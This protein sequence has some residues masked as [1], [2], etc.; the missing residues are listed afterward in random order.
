VAV[1]R[2]RKVRAVAL[3]EL[4]SVVRSKSWLIL[5]FGMPV[6]LLLYSGVVSIPILLEA[7]RERAVALHGVVDE[8][9]ILAL[10]GDVPVAA[11]IPDEIRDAL[12]IAGGEDALA[13][14]IAWSKNHVFRPFPGEAEARAAL[15]AGQIRSYF[16]LPPDFVG[17]GV[18][19]QYSGEAPE[20]AGSDS[21]SS[22][23]SLIVG[24]LL[25]G[26]VPADVAARVEKPIAE[27]RHWTVTDGGE[28][29]RGAG[30]TR[31]LR[32]LVPLGF[33]LLLLVSLLMTGGGLVQATAVEKENKVVEVLLSLADPDEILLGKLLGVGGAGALQ[34]T[35]WFGMAAASGLAF[36]GAITAAGFEVPWRAMAAALVYFAAAYLFYG[37]LML[38]SGSLGANQ[39][40][41]SQWGM[42]WSLPLAVPLVLF[43]ALLNDPHGTAGTVM[44][45]IPFTA[46][47]AVVLRLAADPDGVRWWEVA[48]SLLVLV[49][50]TWFA[51]RL[52]ARLFRVGILL[53]G[54]RPKLRAI[55]RQARLS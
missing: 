2:G 21:R 49:G 13:G 31:V 53:T 30:F 51:I 17:T 35:V 6:I 42:I 25:R 19:E 46:A 44:T 9:G 41:S 43:E 54:A 39:R 38:G 22:L 28:V 14:P 33:A 27:T 4:L 18:V 23:A 24:Q 45:W 40:E 52:G 36:A 37:S 55:L 47:P 34:V 16:R 15:A 12:R 10:S 20:S 7:R 50:A 48:G 3:F 8:S 32:L 1:I 5:T 11:E 26:R 29:K